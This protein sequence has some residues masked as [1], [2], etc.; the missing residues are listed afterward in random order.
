MLAPVT[1]LP[2][3]IVMIRLASTTKV[4][5]TTLSEWWCVVRDIFL[6]YSMVFPVVLDVWD[7]VEWS[8]SSVRICCCCFIFEMYP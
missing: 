3:M 7:N 1:D 5:A 6:L 4:L 8:D 2:L